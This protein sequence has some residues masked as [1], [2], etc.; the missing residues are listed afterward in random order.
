ME[1]PKPEA[2]TVRGSV[3]TSPCLVNTD[4]PAGV[5]AP[6]LDATHDV[7]VHM[8]TGAGKSLCMFQ[9]L[10][11]AQKNGIGV[12]LSPL[13]GLMDEQVFEDAIPSMPNR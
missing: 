6:P 11:A 9:A 13:N 12:M 8:A 2:R 10:L 5:G 3:A 1:V 7:F 4:V